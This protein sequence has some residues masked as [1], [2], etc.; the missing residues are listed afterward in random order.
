MGNSDNVKKIALAAVILIA[1]VVAFMQGKTAVQGEQM[2]IEGG[3]KMPADFKSEKQRAVEAQQ[4]SGTASP[5]PF[6]DTKK[7]V[8]LGG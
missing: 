7:A 6:D 3:F 2:V 8:D 4:A 1:V 5:P